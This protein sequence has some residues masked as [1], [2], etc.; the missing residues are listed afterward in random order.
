MGGGP[1]A[2]RFGDWEQQRGPKTV[3]VGETLCW[4][5]GWKKMVPEI[6]IYHRNPRREETGM[7]GYCDAPRDGPR[8]GGMYGA[9]PSRDRGEGTTGDSDSV[10]VGVLYPRVT[11]GSITPTG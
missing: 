11:T 6:C 7:E 9:P 4:A 2:V 3:S 10:G 5:R 8:S 1:A